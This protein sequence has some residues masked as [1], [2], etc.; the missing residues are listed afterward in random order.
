MT[1]ILLKMFCLRSA[2]IHDRG[3]FV[4]EELEPPS[5]HLFLLPGNT[6]RN[7][8]IKLSLTFTSGKM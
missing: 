1:Q 2:S 6:W 3:F 8:R 4:D 7:I 5:G